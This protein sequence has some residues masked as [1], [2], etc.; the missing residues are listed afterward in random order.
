LNGADLLVTVAERALGSQLPDGSMPSGHNGPYR[1]PETPVRNSGHWL[2]T[3]LKAHGLTGDGRF[4]EAAERIAVLLLQP[5][6]RPGGF[7]Y[8][9][10][11]APGKDHCNGLVGQAWTI[12]AL[13]LAASHFESAE[14]LTVAL[15][16]YRAHSFDP[17]AGLWRICEIDGSSPGFDATLNHQLWF[18][19]AA[20]RLLGGGG[21]ELREA[22]DAFLHKL[23]DNML[24][25]ANGLL[26]QPIP[27]LQPRRW[28]AGQ[29]FSRMVGSRRFPRPLLLRPSVLHAAS[30]YMKCV[31]YHAFCAYA[32]AVLKVHLPEH[33][34]WRLRLADRVAAYL[35]SD[36]Y[37]VLIE[38]ESDY[39][40]AY[41]APGFE[42]PFA[43]ATLTG[44]SDRDAARLLSVWLSRQ[45][46]RTL[47]P[48]S[49]RF[50]RG[51]ADPVTLT[52][53][54]YEMTRFRNEILRGAV[55]EAA[56]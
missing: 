56:G 54:V 42:V 53:R 46:S 47:D 15:E 32:F 52:A 34:F 45:V 16:V 1:H 8:H 48:I 20:S 44:L 38:A 14:H 3:F 41:N 4:R 36:D 6:L 24:L 9:H 19:S 50:E 7:T 27:H 49:L 37:E 23:P 25:F 17:A 2:H 39:G 26:Y 51:T 5:E 18:A 22:L 13:A 31:G 21:V 30:Q 10:R 35:L 12:E 29:P 28:R 11:T 40:F 43:V 55:L 33:A